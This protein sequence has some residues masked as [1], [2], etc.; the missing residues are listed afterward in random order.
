MTTKPG[1]LARAISAAVNLV[2]MGALH[3]PR[4]LHWPN[5]KDANDSWL[6]D[7]ALESR[8]DYTVTRDKGVLRDAPKS[9]FDAITPPEFVEREN[10]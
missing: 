2:M 9:G 5:L 1:G 3:R 10:L 7:L 6:L 8:P 4:S